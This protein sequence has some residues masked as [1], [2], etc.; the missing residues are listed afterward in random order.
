MEIG[1]DLEKRRELVVSDISH[2]IEE[3]VAKRLEKAKAEELRARETEDNAK[4]NLEE[5]QQQE[6]DLKATLDELK[7]YTKKRQM[8]KHE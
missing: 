7:L 3:Y 6:N 4:Y 8:E 1:E 2:H 5:L